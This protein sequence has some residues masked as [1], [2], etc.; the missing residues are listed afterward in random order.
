MPPSSRNSSGTQSTTA[1]ARENIAEN[2]A[3]GK[4]SKET[5]KDR[6]SRKRLQ[7]RISQQCVRE[8][9]AVY[10]KQIEALAGLIKSS[11]NVDRESANSQNAQLNMQMALIEENKELRDALLRMRKK[12][13]SLS[14]AVGAVAG[15]AV[16][17]YSQW[18]WALCG[19]PQ[20]ACTCS[21]AL[22]RP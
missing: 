4:E 11:T 16:P 5:V 17:Y 19:S 13:L 21:V 8:K 20:N 3:K 14:S 10:S 15:K 1:P 12:M 22:K 9:Q 7:N 2:K 6:R 18:R